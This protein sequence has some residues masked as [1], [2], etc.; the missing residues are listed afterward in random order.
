MRPSA[1]PSDELATD[2]VAN[3]TWTFARLGPRA[4]GDARVSSANVLAP[5]A[6]VHLIGTIDENETGLGEVIG[7]RHDHVPHAPRRQR[8]VDPARD[9]ALV[10]DDV[11][12]VHRPLAPQ[13]LRRIG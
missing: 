12:L 8:L 7:G 5:P 2:Q 10:V 13:E 1:D 9:Q 3:P 4:G 6:V 11:A